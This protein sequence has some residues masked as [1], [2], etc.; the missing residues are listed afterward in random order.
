MMKNFWTRAREVAYRRILRQPISNAIKIDISA[1]IL[2][3]FIK[4]LL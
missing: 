4:N 1:Y 2:N 3:L